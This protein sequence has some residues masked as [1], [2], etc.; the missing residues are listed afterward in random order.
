MASKEDLLKQLEGEKD[1][2]DPTVFI[3]SSRLLQYEYNL[4]EKENKY[5]EVHSNKKQ[6][7]AIKVKIPKDKYPDI[8][9]VGRI[10][11]P[12]GGTLKA[13]SQSTGCKFSI[14][15][16]GSTW[17]SGKEEEL[18]KSGD[19][20]YQHLLEELHVMIECYAPG[21]DAFNRVRDAV[22]ELAPLL[23]PEDI[24]FHVNGKSPSMRGMGRGGAPRGMSSRGRG[25][26]PVGYNGGF[27]SPA[28]YDPYSGDPGYGDDAGYD[29]GHDGGSS[30]H[31]SS[32][33]GDS[34]YAPD[35]R[36]Q[37]SAF[38]KAPTRGRGEPRGRMYSPHG[39][40]SRGS[41]RGSSFG[42]RGGGRGK[43]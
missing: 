5:F 21:L 14:Y 1:N 30:F 16:K 8:N 35:Y 6:R 18:L 10:I 11:G 29:Y 26:P 27:D 13:L 24:G 41:S 28:P 31:K 2:L 22:A 12:K 37:P 32:D 25:G 19:P 39:G 7:V 38:G 34:P 42:S 15:G 4:V 17:E 40:G 20:K 36:A 9:F 3:H 43:L 23:S 33:Y